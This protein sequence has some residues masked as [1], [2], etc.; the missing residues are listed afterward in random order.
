MW[1]RRVGALLLPLAGTFPLGPLTRD[2]V[3]GQLGFSTRGHIIIFISTLTWSGST[4][5]L[6]PLLEV[7]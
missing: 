1:I 7:S 6:L 2:V 5:V 3:L 4:G